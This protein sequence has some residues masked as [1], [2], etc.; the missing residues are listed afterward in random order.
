M[1]KLSKFKVIFNGEIATSHKP[2]DVKKKL[3]AL[4]KTNTSK[5][6]KLL[7]GRDFALKSGLDHSAAAKYCKALEKIGLICRI[8]P[9]LTPKTTEEQTPDRIRTIDPVVCQAEAV[10]SVN[11]CPRITG[12]AGGIDVNRTNHR[13]LPLLG[14]ETA[15]IHRAR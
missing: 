1:K 7:T 11:T 14:D 4:L 5:I 6:E 10:Y 3:A 8:E 12:V 13:Y 15:E 9:H 2:E